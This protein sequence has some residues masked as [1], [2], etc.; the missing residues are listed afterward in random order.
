MAQRTSSYAGHP[1]LRPSG[2]PAAVRN[3]SR[4]FR[5]TPRL[6]RAAG[7][8]GAETAGQP[9]PIPQGFCAEPEPSVGHEAAGW[10]RSGDSKHRAQVTPAKRGR[11]GQRAVTADPDESTTAERRASMTWT[12]R[13]KRVFGIGIKT[14]AACGGA[15]RIVAHRR[16]RRHREDPHPPGCERG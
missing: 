3:R 2:Q 14:C 15:A 4:R 5:R 10:E 6:H 9:H 1:A 16:S 7:G 8:S 11:E 13:L 12:Q